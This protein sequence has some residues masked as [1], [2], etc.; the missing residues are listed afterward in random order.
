MKVV[1]VKPHLQKV[2]IENCTPCGICER[3]KNG[4]AADC[5]FEFE[6]WIYFQPQP[7]F[8]EYLCVHKNSLYPFDG[9]SFEEAGDYRWMW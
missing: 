6:N 1:Y 9:L 4:K 7:G 2:I 3:C 8:A 5:E